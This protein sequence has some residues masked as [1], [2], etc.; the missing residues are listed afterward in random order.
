MIDAGT[1]V[2]RWAKPKQVGDVLEDGHP[3]L[4]PGTP[5]G[6]DVSWGALDAWAKSLA[7]GQPSEIILTGFCKRPDGFYWYLEE[8]NPAYLWV[9][10]GWRE[11]GGK[12]APVC[13]EC[14]GYPRHARGCSMA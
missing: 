3:R 10:L 6:F 9:V 5:S 12:L 2:T 8:L 1:V 11:K 14:D 7:T 13:I 4:M